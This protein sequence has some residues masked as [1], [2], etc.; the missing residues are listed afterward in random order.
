[1]SGEAP[2]ASPG[3]FLPSYSCKK[4]APSKPF[5]TSSPSIRIANNIVSGRRP[6]H[7]LHLPFIPP[8]HPHSSPSV[9]PPF[10]LHHITPFAAPQPPACPS[11]S[12]APDTDPPRPPLRAKFAK[13]EFPRTLH[14]DA[15]PPSPFTTLPLHRP[16]PANLNRSP[17]HK[18]PGNVPPGDQFPEKIFFL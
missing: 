17:E 5:S 15:T 9:T 3:F 7:S 18:R 14:P 8:Q 2:P 4:P 6:P 16:P 10:I 12:A 11:P 1:V 13:C